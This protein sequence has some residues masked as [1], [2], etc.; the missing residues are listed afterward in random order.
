MNA[1]FASLP[2]PL[3]VPTNVLQLIK[4]IQIT[5]KSKNLDIILLE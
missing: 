3:T 2:T 5:D 1:A 4:K